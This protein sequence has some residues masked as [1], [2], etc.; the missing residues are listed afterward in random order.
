MKIPS[1]GRHKVLFVQHIPLQDISCSNCSLTYF[2][3][4]LIQGIDSLIH[5]AELNNCENGFTEFFQFFFSVIFRHSWNYSCWKEKIQW[6]AQFARLKIHITCR[7][8]W[9]NEPITSLWFSKEILKEKAVI[10]I[11]NLSFLNFGFK[12]WKT[13]QGTWKLNKNQQPSKSYIS[14]WKIMSR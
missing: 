13:L 2:W 9:K 6:L 3:F 4:K 1:S 10:Y 11:L 7:N 12:Y 8:I 5:G 14:F